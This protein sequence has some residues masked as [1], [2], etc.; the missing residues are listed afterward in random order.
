MLM[1]FSHCVLIS[2]RNYVRVRVC[3]CMSSW[4]LPDHVGSACSTQHTKLIRRFWLFVR[5]FC[6]LWL[7]LCFYFGHIISFGPPRF[8]LRNALFSNDVWLYTLA[9]AWCCVRFFLFFFIR[10]PL[11][12]DSIFALALSRA[13]NLL[14][15]FLL[16]CSCEYV[17]V[18]TCCCLTA[19]IY[20]TLN[21]NLVAVL[22]FCTAVFV[23]SCLCFIFVDI[24]H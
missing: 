2:P 13:L 21:W 15:V 24:T 6:A 17:R 22:F 7:F 10:L 14:L 5:F 9:I 1:T 12:L 4:W 16:W 3:V 19:V 11:V 8:H 20:I 23:C 18:W